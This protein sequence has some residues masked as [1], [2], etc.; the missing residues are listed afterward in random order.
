MNGVVLGD[1]VSA[2][3]MDS[4]CSQLFFRWSD[5]RLCM[6]SGVIFTMK[7]FRATAAISFPSGVAVYVVFSLPLTDTVVPCSSFQGLFLSPS[8]G[9]KSSLLPRRG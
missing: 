3:L 7:W 5:S 2:D 9:F 8:S 6:F 4:L 1:V